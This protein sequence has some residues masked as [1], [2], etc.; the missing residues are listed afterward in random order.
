MARL[1]TDSSA[2]PSPARP[3][4]TEPS[5]RAPVVC[6]DCVRKFRRVDIVVLSGLESV[7]AG[8]MKMSKPFY[9]VYSSLALSMLSRLNLRNG[10]AV[11]E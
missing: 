3:S 11:N 6:A 10:F 2:L 4:N 9:D 5:V 7:A 8:P 1:D